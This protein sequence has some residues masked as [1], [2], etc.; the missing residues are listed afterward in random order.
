[1]V[2]C[3]LY[4]IYLPEVPLVLTMEN[5]NISTFIFPLKQGFYLNNINKC[6]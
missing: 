4:F 3:A 1:M 5:L 2:Q 6:K